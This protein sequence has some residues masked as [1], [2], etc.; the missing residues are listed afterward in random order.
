[1][2][3]LMT[4][5]EESAP[6]E[7]SCVRTLSTRVLQGSREGFPLEAHDL[8]LRLLVSTGF[9]D[10]PALGFEFLINAFRPI[11]CCREQSAWRRIHRSRDQ[12]IRQLSAFGLKGTNNFYFVKAAHG[13]R[14]ALT[15]NIGSTDISWPLAT[16][17]QPRWID[18]SLTVQ[19]PCN[20]P[21]LLA[22]D[23]APEQPAFLS[24]MGCPGPPI[25][26]AVQKEEGIGWQGELGYPW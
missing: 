18:S 24:S 10:T 23:K 19:T 3:F 7:S 9:V 4:H 13:K 17:L 12:L 25:K 6:G 15:G 8:F 14:W 26:S 2:G 11:S 16:V 21:W 1:M 5:L 22:K 20:V